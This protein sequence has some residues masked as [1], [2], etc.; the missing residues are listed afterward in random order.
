MYF[1]D[2][3]SYISTDNNHKQSQEETPDSTGKVDQNNPLLRG[4]RGCVFT[5][6]NHKQS[7]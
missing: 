2:V 7:Q 3:G 4:G 1:R 6:N 5:D